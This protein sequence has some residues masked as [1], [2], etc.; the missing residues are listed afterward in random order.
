MF[1]QERERK[2]E[3][4][5]VMLKKIRPTPKQPKVN[6]V[7]AKNC[8]LQNISSIVKYSKTPHFATL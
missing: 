8:I 2:M 3:K 4:M 7:F 5:Q 1:L 6:I